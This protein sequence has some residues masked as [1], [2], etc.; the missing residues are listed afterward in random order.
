M[1]VGRS[2]GSGWRLAR[3]PLPLLDPLRPS[4]GVNR[5]VCQYMG[6]FALR[7]GTQ[8]CMINR[9]DFAKHSLGGSVEKVW[10]MRR[11]EPNR[12]RPVLTD[13]RGVGSGGNR[14]RSLPSSR[15]WSTALCLVGAPT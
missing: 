8:W 13:S 11:F 9:P 6:L 12:S 10:D 14:R 1:V 3:L 4:V 7:A 15:P 2:A 5:S